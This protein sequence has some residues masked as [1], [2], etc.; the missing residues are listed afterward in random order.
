MAL[1]KDTTFEEKLNF[2]LKNDMRIFV[3]FDP[4]SGESEIFHFDGLLLQKVC[5]FWTRKI[6]KSCFVKNEFSHKKLKVML[7]KSSVYNVVFAQ[8]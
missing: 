3:N 5:N 1:K 8:K 2:Y 7:D 4:S 6:Q